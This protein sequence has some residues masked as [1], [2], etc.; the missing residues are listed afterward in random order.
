M[1][2]DRKILIIGGDSGWR[3]DTLTFLSRMH[4][5]AETAADL[6]EAAFLLDGRKDFAMALIR[7]ARSDHD[8]PLQIREMRDIHPGLAVVLLSDDNG[9]ETPLPLLEEGT[10]DHV[11][12]PDNPT[13][14]LSVLKNEFLKH[15][16]QDKN[17]RCRK[18]LTEFRSEH[19]KSYKKSQDLEEIYDSTLENLMTA[20][21]LRDVETFGHSITVAKYSQV[22]A[23]L[24]GISDEA[25]LSNIRKGALLHDIGKIAIPDSI[26]KKNGPLSETEWGKIKHHPALGFG[27]IKEIKLVESIGNIILHHHERYDGTGYPGHLEGHAIPVEA[28]VFALADALDAITSRRPYS[29]QRSFREASEEI[30]AKSGAQFD[31]A[32]VQAFCSFPL[33]KWEKIRYEST[34]LLPHFEE[35]RRVAF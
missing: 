24:L 12:A 23:R 26:L 29:E 18:K 17:T 3:H 30:Q 6:K 34:R 2:S 21:D 28:R 8:V 25:Q 16:L 7:Q 33:E 35:F 13:G 11:A 19:R 22:L 1:A 20:L 10:V 32:V 5:T 9:R 31:P 27:L 4:Y 14:I 15:D